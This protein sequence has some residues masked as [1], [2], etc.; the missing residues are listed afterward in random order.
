MAGR[1]TLVSNWHGRPA[2][3]YGLSGSDLRGGASKDFSSPRIP[4]SPG[5]FPGHRSMVSGSF[6]SA[7]QIVNTPIS[8]DAM[9]AM[10]AVPPPVIL[11]NHP[12]I[13]VG[14]GE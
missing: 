13:A 8:A 5:G 9:R 6:A 14:M 7:G 3:R 1:V 2:T 10:V 12:I 4:M 11:A